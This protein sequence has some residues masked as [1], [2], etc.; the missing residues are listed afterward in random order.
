[1]TY[2]SQ[3]SFDS[4]LSDRNVPYASE[5]S[6]TR[7]QNSWSE[8]FDG[9]ES[10]AARTRAIAGTSSGAEMQAARIAAATSQKR[11]LNIVD[12]PD[13]HS[14]GVIAPARAESPPATTASARRIR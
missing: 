3:S 13:R 4:R 1:M 12:T 2:W 9:S 8:A 6:E 14:G 7:R 10:A 5:K 11:R